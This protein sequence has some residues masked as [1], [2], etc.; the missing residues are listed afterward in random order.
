MNALIFAQ[1]TFKEAVRKKVLLGVIVLTLGFV[2]LY[3]LACYIAFRELARDTFMPIEGKVA[4]S[5]EI[6]LAGLY[7]T[8]FIS[9]LLAI[10]GAVGT[11]STEIEQGTLHALVPKPVNR[12]EIIFG[13]WLGFAVMLSLYVIV[14]SA[15]VTGIVYFFGNY[16]PTQPFLA[17]VVMVLEVLVLLTVTILGSV[18]FSTITNGVVVFM[19]YG[20]ALVAGLV[21]QLGALLS[22]ATMINIGVTVSLIIPSDALWK[23]ASSLIQPQ[24]I[25]PRMVGPF[26]VLSPPSIWM[27]VYSLGYTLVVLFLAVRYF[28]RKDL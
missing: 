17:L 23:L 11:I 2:A 12:W 10:F 6:L 28:S 25:F 27:L 4:L 19:L 13:K 8:N 22:N 16:F 7:V 24:I 9:G 26:T 5:N 21:E 15:I 20:I 14:T 3:T 18:N 1:F